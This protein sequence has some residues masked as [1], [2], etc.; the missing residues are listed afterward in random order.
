MFELVEVKKGYDKST[1]CMP[2]QVSWI[3]KRPFTKLGNIGHNKADE[4]NDTTDLVRFNGEDKAAISEWNDYGYGGILSVYEKKKTMLSANNICI[5]DTTTRSRKDRYLFDYDAV[6]EAGLNALGHNDWTITEPQISVFGN[7]MKIISLGGLS[8]GMTIDDF[9]EGIS[10]PR[11]STLMSVFF[12]LVMVCRLLL[13]NMERK[14]LILQ[15]DI[16]NVKFRLI[17]K[18]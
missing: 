12:I 8:R 10:H 2:R 3:G 6:N 13:I 7:R 4:L 14:H 16:S 5:S 1:V 9:Y 17:K 11:N 15:R 18:V